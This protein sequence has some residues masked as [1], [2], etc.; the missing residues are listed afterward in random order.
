MVLRYTRTRSVDTRPLVSDSRRGERTPRVS[1][2]E[3]C[4]SVT[5]CL[6]PCLLVGCNRRLVAGGYIRRRLAG[7]TG[8][9][10]R[11]VGLV[12]R[13][14]RPVQRRRRVPV[15]RAGPT[16]QPTHRQCVRSRWIPEQ[17]AVSTCGAQS[18]CRQVS[19]SSVIG[20]SLTELT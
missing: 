13:V 8:S 19:S 6:R 12:V 16:S 20:P 10:G 11:H 15:F 2:G 5:M 14:V 17:A 4:N 1:L 9:P 18:F 7:S 3:D